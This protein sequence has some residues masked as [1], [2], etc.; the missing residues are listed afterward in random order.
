MKWNSRLLAA[1]VLACASAVSMAQV[2]PPKEI[3]AGRSQAD[4][5]TVWWQWAASFPDDES[6]VGDRSG[7]RCGAS[8][9]GAVWF[10]AGTFETR[11]TIR[12]C[13]VPR[14]KYLFFPLINYMVYPPEGSTAA[15]ATLQAGA[16]DVTDGV[17]SLVLEVDGV[18]G[19]ALESHRMVP[20]RCFNL[21]GRDASEDYVPAA[22]NGYYV[23]LRPLKPGKHT[24]NFGGALPDMRQAVTYTLIVE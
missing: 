4:W 16:A 23:M 14:G 9:S 21:Y 13:T 10:L 24:L 5:T 1:A 20:A 7:A 3:V 2:V 15:C 18:R 11:R 12:T 6:P 22:A 8:Q 19:T 17:S